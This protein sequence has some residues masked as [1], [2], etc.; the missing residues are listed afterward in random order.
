LTLQFVEVTELTAIAVYF[1]TFIIRQFS[2]PFLLL[3]WSP[4]LHLD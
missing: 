4:Q 3:Q 2:S 1:V